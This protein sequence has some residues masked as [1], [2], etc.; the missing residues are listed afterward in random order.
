MEN[1]SL[2]ERE[3]M[4]TTQ[5]GWMQDG[6]TPD[7]ET[8]REY[9]EPAKQEYRADEPKNAAIIENYTES[10]KVSEFQLNQQFL[11]DNDLKFSYKKPPKYADKK[12]FDRRKS[13]RPSS[14][15]VKRE[16][17]ENLNV[18]PSDKSR[19]GSCIPISSLTLFDELLPNEDRNAKNENN[20]PQFAS[21]LNFRR[22]NSAHS[23][24]KTSKAVSKTSRL[25]SRAI[26]GGVSIPQSVRGYES[27]KNIPNS[28]CFKIQ[29]SANSLLT[30]ITFGSELSKNNETWKCSLNAAKNLNKKH[31]S[32]SF[33]HAQK[34]AKFLQKPDQTSVEVTQMEAKLTEATQQPVED[35]PKPVLKNAQNLPDTTRKPNAYPQKPPQ[36]APGSFTSKSEVKE[37]EMT[38][39]EPKVVKNQNKSRPCSASKTKVFIPANKHWVKT[40][41]NIEHDKTTYKVHCQLVSSNLCCQSS[42]YHEIS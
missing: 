22:P 20:S 17:P 12:S 30:T 19:P 5:N 15:T 27:S 9:V 4:T 33:D 26:S 11:I 31:E 7:K 37:T 14:G 29:K 24:T 32:T 41:P 18:P 8:K 25:S 10:L 34:N 2:L 39:S 13:K 16:S 6:F 36:S 40:S 28:N 1:K 42:K 3:E 21:N 35:S 23:E 38:D